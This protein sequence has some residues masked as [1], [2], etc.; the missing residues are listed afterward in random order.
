MP[1]PLHIIPADRRASVSAGLARVL[2]RAAP[3]ELA[4][5]SNGAS[6]ARIYRACIGGRACIVR[7][8]P[9][10]RQ[11][12]R[13]PRRTFACM[14]AASDAGVAPRL[15]HADPAAGVTLM[16]LIVEQPLDWHPGGGTGLVSDLGTLVARLQAT[17][18]FAPLADFPTIIERLFAFVL[19]SNML[20]PGLLDPHRAAFARIRAAYRWDEDDLVSSHNE[21]NPHNI[22][23]D[24]QRLWLIDWEMAFRNDPLVDLAIVANSFART[25]ELEDTLLRVALGAPQ[26][27]LVRARFTLMRRLTQLYYAALALTVTAHAPRAAPLTS[28][29]PASVAAHNGAARGT[30][31]RSHAEIEALGLQ[32]LASFLADTATPEFEEALAI[33]GGR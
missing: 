4:L 13:D 28:L 29:T 27:R 11:G 8:E 26:E 22:L 10:E 23:F 33:A 32:A 7:L 21:L 31:R 24:G 12:L 1:D 15:L 19:G 6:G 25:P 2:G 5:I 30:M 18:A 17:P 14:Q 16:D 20:A 9:T 3:D